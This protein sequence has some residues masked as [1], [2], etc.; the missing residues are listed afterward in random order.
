MTP[1]SGRLYLC[2][3]GREVLFVVDGAEVVQAAV[4]ADG[5]VEAFDVGEDLHLQLVAGRPGPPVDHLLLQGREKRLA[6]AV[7]TAPI[8]ASTPE[9]RSAL[10][11]S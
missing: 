7:P 11:E 3:S 9:A 2:R 1:V 8:E 10:P 6:Q 5:V 4:P